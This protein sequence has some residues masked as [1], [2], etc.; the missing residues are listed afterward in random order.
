M[1]PYTSR[2]GTRST[3]RALRADGWHLLVSATGVHRTEGFPYAIDNGER[4]AV[5]CAKCGATSGQRCR[6]DHSHIV[7]RR[8]NDLGHPN[9]GA[10]VWYAFHVGRGR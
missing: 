7:P 8:L 5:P 9:G 6:P 1:I 4:L 2:T 3:L 10:G